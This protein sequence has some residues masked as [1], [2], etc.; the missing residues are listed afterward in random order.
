MQRSSVLLPE[1]LGPITQTTE[2]AR[3]LQV[4][5][6][7]HLELTEA[8]VHAVQRQHRILARGLS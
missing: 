7:K 4:D 6:A 1:P 2:P 8:L 5:A 3:D